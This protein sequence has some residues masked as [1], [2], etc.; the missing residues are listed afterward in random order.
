EMLLPRAGLGLTRDGRLLFAGRAIRTFGFGYLSVILPLYLARHG[1]SA[2]DIGAVLTATLI[3]D[4]LATSAFAA[5]ADRVGR[6]RILMIA[7]VFVAL[8]GVLLAVAR[9]RWLLILGAVLGTL[10]PGGQE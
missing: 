5:V 2:G 3:E 1:F 9:A 6:R 4:A 7:P 8:A 10:S